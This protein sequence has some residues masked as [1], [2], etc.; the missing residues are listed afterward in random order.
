MTKKND[1]SD[2]DRFNEA[3][4]RLLKG[5][6]AKIKGAMEQE[7]REREQEGSRTGKRGPGRPPKDASAKRAK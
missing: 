3:M 7:K 4:D 2:Y 5:D 6:P 1:A